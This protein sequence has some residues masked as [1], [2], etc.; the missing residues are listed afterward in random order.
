[1]PE[2]RSAVKNKPRKTRSSFNFNNK[3]IAELSALAR[4]VYPDETGD[5]VLPDDNKGTALANALIT[6]L[7]RGGP[8]NCRWLFDF[9]KDRAPWLDPNEIDVTALRPKRADILGAEIG[10]TAELRNQLK[11]TTIRPCD[12]TTEQ[13]EILA[14]DRRRQRDKERK[15]RQYAKE[16]RT[17]RSQSLSQLC[18]WHDQGISRRTWER[19][20]KQAQQENQ[21]L[22]GDC[23]SLSARDNP[24]ANVSTNSHTVASGY[25]CDS[26]SLTAIERKENEMSN[27][28]H[29]KPWIAEGVS[30]AT[31]YRRRKAGKAKTQHVFY[32]K[33]N[34]IPFPKKWVT[35]RLEE[36]PISECYAA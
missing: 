1:M 14:K 10:L 2:P 33:S 7:S 24:V 19:R 35:P 22:G 29:T 11:I 25:I 31:W 16:G 12:Q 6:H 4:C 8:R 34:V 32:C 13:F 23:V 15:R 26:L 27:I 36:I 5:Y 17:P 3:R 20:R 9:C 18:P 28:K 21:S 30:R